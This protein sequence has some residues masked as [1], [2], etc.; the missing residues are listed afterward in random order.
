L[1]AERGGDALAGEVVFGGAEAAGEH[2][3]VRAVQC[4][5]DGVGEVL[6]VIADDGF[7]GDRDAELVEAGGEGKRVGVLTVGRQHLRTDGDDLSEHWIEDSA[8]CVP[9]RKAPHPTA[10]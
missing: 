9:S 5:A 1:E 4:D 2:D 10:R 7:E 8:S 3:D 6:A